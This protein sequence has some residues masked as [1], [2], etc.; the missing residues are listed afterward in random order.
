MNN[1]Q[2]Q[3]LVARPFLNDGEFKRTV[4]F[5]AE[6]N[7]Q[8]SLGFILNKPM[9][10]TLKDVLPGM[11]DLKIPVYYG[12]PVA[13]NQ[14]FYVHTAGKEIKN[15]LHIQSNYYWSGDFAEV[16]DMLKTRR[17]S[18]S[19]IR[20]FIGYSGWGEQ[21]LEKELNEKA[22][23]NLDSFTTEILNKHPEDMWREQVA[24]LGANY[25]VFADTP[26]E[27]SLN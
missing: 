12:G 13:Q 8:G 22:W 7:D 2:G 1:L 24:R 27:P 14:L 19:Q 21:Q 11:D 15:S 25:K 3:I 5:L 10:L 20:F 26:Q 9:H 6:H 23:A 17:M 16:I 4:I 18:P